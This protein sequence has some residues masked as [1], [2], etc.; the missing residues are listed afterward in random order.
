MEKKE[1]DFHPDAVIKSY[2]YLVNSHFPKNKVI[3]GALTTN[4]RY[5]GP[6]EALFHAIIRKNYGCTHFLVG[7]D[8]AGV[9]SYYGEYDAQKLCIDY[10]S[11]LG[12]KIV[13]VRG[14]F[15]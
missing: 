10:E 4:M 5:A 1:G 2:K 13:K 3:L 14:P 12:I 15:L 7:R 8:H 11:E 9:G 6:R